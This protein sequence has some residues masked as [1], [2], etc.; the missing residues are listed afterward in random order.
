MK[1]RSPRAVPT[2]PACGSGDS[3]R[4]YD[5]PGWRSNSRMGQGNSWRGLVDQTLGD[6]AVRV[7][8]PVAK[9]W[10][11]R[12]LHIERPEV[13]FRHENLFR[14]RRCFLNDL[15]GRIRDEALP[16]EFDALA[17]AFH[18]MRLMSYAIRH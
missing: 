18:R 8:P 7:N 10:P 9:K 12:S 16:P 3:R 14:A 5:E 1:A 4:S 2:P 17:S 6:L 15:P 13:H 11:V